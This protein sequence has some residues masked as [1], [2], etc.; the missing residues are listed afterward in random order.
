[1]R[2]I[3]PHTMAHTKINRPLPPQEPIGSY[4]VWLW[5][6]LSDVYLIQ[7]QAHFK[8]RRASAQPKNHVHEE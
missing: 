5:V 1:M 6:E 7:H 4:F 3:S 8:G 2:D